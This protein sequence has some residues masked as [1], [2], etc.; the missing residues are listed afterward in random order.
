V[1]RAFKWSF[2]PV[3]GLS[4]VSLL[5]FATDGALYF[6]WYI[7]FIYAV[8]AA[9]VGLTSGLVAIINSSPNDKTRATSAGALAGVA[10]GAI[11]LAVTCFVNLNTWEG[12]GL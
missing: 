9:L 2:F 4:V 10:V 6:S 11:A 1:S 5:G 8:V 12:I 3:L 7:G